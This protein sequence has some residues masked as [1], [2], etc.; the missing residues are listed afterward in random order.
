[1]LKYIAQVF[2]IFVNSSL[3]VVIASCICC[4]A[5]F[6]LPFGNS[7][8][9]YAS[10]LLLGS[11]SWIIYIL[12]RI[13]DNQKSND[14][15]SERHEFHKKNQFVLQ[16]IVLGLI[17]V[18][19]CLLVFQKREVLF[20]GLFIGCLVIL[21]FF[22]INK[23]AKGKYFKEIF[24][25]IIY[26]LAI[27]GIPFIEKTSI[28]FSEWI[29]ALVFFNIIFQ[30]TLFFSVKEYSEDVN[31]ENICAILPPIKLRRTINY[32][33]AINIFLVIFFFSG[34]FNYTQ[35]LAWLFLLISI[36]ISFLLSL[37]GK[38]LKNE[39]YRWIVDG[40]LFLPLFIF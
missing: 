33:G 4:V 5:F 11:I 1:M 40:L 6:K 35:K 32:L 14:I 17:L 13:F 2:K 39:N 37:P 30:N 36:S 8:I 7:S 21:Y 23:T 29:L 31:L 28:N 15:K 9:N 26:C 24:M 38:Y 25:P 3:N 20:F 12:D 22:I 10:I 27:V 18:S 16:F 34:P 19:F